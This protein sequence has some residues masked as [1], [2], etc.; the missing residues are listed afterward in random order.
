MVYDAFPSLTQVQNLAIRSQQGATAVQPQL[1]SVTL[2]AS[3]SAPQSAGGPLAKAPGPLPVLGSK[4]GQCE[5]MAES[6]KKSEHG[7][8]PSTDTRGLG[9]THNTATVSTHPLITTGRHKKHTG[10]RAMW[11]CRETTPTASQRERDTLAADWK[12]K[13]CVGRC[14]AH[15]P[16]VTPILS[17]TASPTVSVV[18]LT[19]NQRFES[20]NYICFYSFPRQF[21]P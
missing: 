9:V 18:G 8:A 6:G 4:G 15:G 2:K 10:K 17:T 16:L 5:G 20:Y 3:A 19:T 1:Q 12:G 11:E 7:I 13:G 21:I 14:P